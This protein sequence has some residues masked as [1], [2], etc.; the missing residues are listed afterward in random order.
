M[1]FNHLFLV[2]FIDL[3]ES[4]AC[5][6]NDSQ[7]GQQQLDQKMERKWRIVDCPVL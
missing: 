4:Q 2:Y 6:R 1:R 5:R 3:N 7:M